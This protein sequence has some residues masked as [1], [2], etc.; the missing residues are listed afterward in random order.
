[1]H[2]LHTHNFRVGCDLK[3]VVFFVVVVLNTPFLFR[4][5]R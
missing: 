5:A 4:E 3:R 2:L 1:M